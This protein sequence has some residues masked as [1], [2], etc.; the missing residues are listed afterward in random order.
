MIRIK[1]LREEKGISQKELG[2]LLN[3][4]QNTISNWE[5]GFREPDSKAIVKLAE[6][7]D[8]TTD[9]LLGSSIVRNPVETQASHMAEEVVLSDDDLEKIEEILAKVRARHK[10]Q[11]NGE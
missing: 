3:V 8:C 6:V 10:Q 11:N 4:A 5:N 2:K 7:L 1:E 9:Y